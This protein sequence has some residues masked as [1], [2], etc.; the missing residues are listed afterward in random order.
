MGDANED[1]E[2]DAWD[3]V[4]TG[5]PSPESLVLEAER[6]RAIEGCLASLPVEFRTVAIL[7]DVQGYPYEEV[8]SVVGVPLGTVKSRLARARARLRDCLERRGELFKDRRRLSHGAM[9]S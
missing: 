4:G 7:A 5:E 3:R 6:R 9:S 1:G 8:A 2:P